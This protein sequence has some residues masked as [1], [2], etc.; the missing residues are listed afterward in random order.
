MPSIADLRNEYAGRP[1]LESTVLADPIAQFELW[2]EEGIKA[3]VYEPT[4]V[5]LATVEPDGNPGARI[6]LLKHFDQAG[7]CFFTNYQSAKGAAIAANPQASLLFYWAELH[8]QVRIAGRVEKTTTKESDN[9]FARRPRGSQISAWASNQSDVIGSRAAIDEAT[10]R[11]QA[12]FE[13]K[14]VPCP[15]HW[16]GYRLVNESIEFWQGQPNRLH[17]RLRFTRRD[18]SEWA[19]ER[20][21]P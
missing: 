2:M 6:V 17:D 18:Q 12:E 5:T 7:F 1:L 21:A 10:A 11:Y 20:L 4:A 3:Q 13:G 14:P 15:P 19:I 9:Y 16:G 8:R